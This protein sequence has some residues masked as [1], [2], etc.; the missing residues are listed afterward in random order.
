MDRVA[1]IDRSVLGNPIAVTSTGI[2][3]YHEM[4]NDADNTALVPLMLTGDFMIDEGE[5]FAFIDEVIP[6]FRWG[7]KDGTTEDAQ[8][9]V[10]LLVRDEPGA[11]AR[12]YGPFV[13]TKA[14]PS[15]TP[16]DPIDFTRPRGK[17]AQLEISST[18][19]GSFWRLGAVRFRYAPDGKR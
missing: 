16:A 19:T 12:A 18:D 11:D 8:I 17:L 6:D 7:L 10:R 13:L 5:D 4:G 3:Y 1:W 9:A 2:I 15:F 14:S